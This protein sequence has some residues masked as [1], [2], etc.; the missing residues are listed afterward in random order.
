MRTIPVEKSISADHQVTTYDHIREIID[1]T[2]GPI[3]IMECLCRKSSR[4]AGKS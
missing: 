2:E 3:I 4:M 1:K